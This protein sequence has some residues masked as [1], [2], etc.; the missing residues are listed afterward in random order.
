MIRILSSLVA[1]LIIAPL[2]AQML[3][4]ET[5]K[6]IVGITIDQLRGDYLEQFRHAFGDKGFKR[7]FEEGLV[8]QNM[9]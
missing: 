4:N 1:I 6:L 3:P 5:P 8:Y 2:Q 9:E 7:L